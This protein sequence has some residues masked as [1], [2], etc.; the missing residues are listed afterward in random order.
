MFTILQATVIFIRSNKVR[1]QNWP[2]FSRFIV[3][4]INLSTRYATV[5]NLKLSSFECHN[6]VLMVSPNQMCYGKEF[7][8]VLSVYYLL[9]IKKM[10]LNLR[11]CPRSSI[12]LSLAFKLCG[13]S[14]A[15]M[16]TFVPMWQAVVV[17]TFWAI[18][19]NEFFF[20]AFWHWACIGIHFRFFSLT[21]V[22]D[23]FVNLKNYYCDFQNIV[24]IS[25]KIWIWNGWRLINPKFGLEFLPFFSDF[26]LKINTHL[27][28]DIS[29]LRRWNWFFTNGAYRNLDGLNFWS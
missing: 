11:I 8:L 4:A 19:C 25:W 27:I 18:H 14:L 15:T 17:S 28:I 20:S 7:I 5:F 22:L 23:V 10:F 6:L 21:V 16:V 13:F 1:F 12:F 26:P 3:R 9:G 29:I 2:V 24:C